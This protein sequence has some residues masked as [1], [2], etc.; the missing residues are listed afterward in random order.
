MQALLNYLKKY[1]LC[2]RCKYYW[3]IS[4]VVANVGEE[5][6][7]TVGDKSHAERI[8]TQDF[9]EGQVTSHIFFP[10]NI[11]YIFVKIVINSTNKRFRF[12]SIIGN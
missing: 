4:V 11:L 10:S 2:K 8:N 5:A 1:Q 7:D 3:L 12:K 9:H 6:L